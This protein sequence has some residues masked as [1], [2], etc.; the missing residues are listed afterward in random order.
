MRP[1]AFAAIVGI[2]SV[3]TPEQ[4]AEFDTAMGSKLYT[5]EFGDGSDSEVPAIWIESA[6]E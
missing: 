4:A 5:I 2:R 1:G 6:H 3:E